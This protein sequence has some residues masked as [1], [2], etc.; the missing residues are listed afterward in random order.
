VGDLAYLADGSVGLRVIDVSRPS[1]PVQRGSL[2]LPGASDV[3]VERGLA[4]VTSNAPA[5]R[6]A[7]AMGSLHSVDVSKATA[8]RALGSLEL[9]W[10]AREIQV[11]DG[12]AHLVTAPSFILNGRPRFVSL[13]AIDVSDPAHPHELGALPLSAATSLELVNGFVYV[14]DGSTLRILD[15]GPEYRRPVS[16]VAID[17]KPGDAR[18]AID[19]SGRGSV[20]VAILGGEGLDVR[21]VDRRSLAFGPGDAPAAGSGAFKDVDR[22]GA[23]DLVARFLKRHSGLGLG[24]SE[25]CLRGKL[26]DGTRFAGCDA[27]RTPPP[28]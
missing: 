6:F 23:A 10:V 2:A 9:T 1:M 5:S 11:A 13:R 3:A 17:V 18:N 15:F 21:T 26:L 27:V 22:D 28:R 12:I 7:P 14:A 25:A 16:P 19:P 20:R 24:D 4:Y 8:P